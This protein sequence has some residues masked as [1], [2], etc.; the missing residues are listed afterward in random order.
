MSVDG[1]AAIETAP[2]AEGAAAETVDP[3]SSLPVET[4]EAADA[5]DAEKAQDSPASEL[6][7]L[8]VVLCA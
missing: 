2:T 1:I 5:P 6:H 7:G 3:E 4:A 8:P